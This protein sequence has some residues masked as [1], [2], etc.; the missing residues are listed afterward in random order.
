MA[1]EKSKKSE[2][3]F[4]I[5]VANLTYPEAAQIFSAS[6]KSLDAIKENCIIVLDTNALLVPFTTGKESLEQIRKTY[7]FLVAQKR[8]VVPGQVAREFAKNRANKL[9]EL[10]QQ[11]SR[12]ANVPGLQK[13]RYPL[14]ESLDDYQETVRLEKQID[15]LL[16]TY[17]DTIGKI[18]DHIRTWTWDDPVS[19]LY[20]ALFVEDVIVDSPIDK[21]SARTE[22]ARRQ[23]HDLPPGYKDSSKKDNGIGDFLIWQTI[24][25]VGKAQHKSVI[26]VSGEEKPDWWYKSEGQ[27]LYPRYELVDEFRRCSGGESFH[28]IQFSQFLDLYGATE[29]VVEEVRQKEQFVT[30]TSM[31]EFKGGPEFQTRLRNLAQ[32][33]HIVDRATYK[34]LVS[35]FPGSKVTIVGET[36]SGNSVFRPD[37][38]I[39]DST[40]VST[41]ANVVSVRTGNLGRELARISER[42]LAAHYALSEGT[43]KGALVIVVTD[44]LEFLVELAARFESSNKRIKQVD[45]KFAYLSPRGELETF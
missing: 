7:N 41:A 39:V 14:L 26:F 34:W 31:P 44:N 22:L 40:G 38:V 4:D 28:M 45:Y 11:L 24:L 32:L 37:F 12:K 35:N 15:D 21:E 3:E 8:L 17:R 19:K 2:G 16:R 42:A 5:F 20:S 18:L 13:G 23:A 43:F 36:S 33:G 29:K 1:E 10:F 6:L 27:T 9:V 30:P 25:D